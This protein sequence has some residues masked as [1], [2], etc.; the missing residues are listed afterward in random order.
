VKPTILR[1][2]L[3]AL[4]TAFTTAIVPVFAQTSTTTP[5]ASTPTSSIT[6]NAATAL[7]NNLIPSPLTDEELHNEI[8]GRR[9]YLSKPLPQALFLR[10]LPQDFNLK[11]D[12]PASTELL[13]SF[14]DN[15]S[16]TVYANITGTAEAFFDQAQ[17]SLLGQGFKK[18]SQFFDLFQGATASPDEFS[19]AFCSTD[20]KT[21]VQISKS[22]I[23]F[24]PENST[25]PQVVSVSVE[26]NNPFVCGNNGWALP[27]AP[28]PI[29]AG[30]RIIGS[31]TG[32]G[33]GVTTSAMAFMSDKPS[34]D[35]FRQYNQELRKIG[36]KPLFSNEKGQS[37]ISVWSF[38][39]KQKE[40]WLATLAVSSNPLG[41]IWNKRIVSLTLT[42]L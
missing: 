39:S 16:T 35:V 7:P 6:A 30:I 26:K 11:L 2:S 3:L 14:S 18:S 36:M 19:R 10:Q 40:A 28:L 4:A 31:S 27:I 22:Y 23:G 34:L 1:S 20:N 38:Q 32:R 17:K 24:I 5:P 29:V 25:K 42:R 13:G 41:T 8:L 9:L 33:E 37:F 12:F 21:L 15:F